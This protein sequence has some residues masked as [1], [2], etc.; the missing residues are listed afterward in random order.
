MDSLPH[1]LLPACRRRN[2]VQAAYVDAALSA[3]TLVGLT[4]AEGFALKAGV[5]AQVLLRVLVAGGPCKAR[6]RPRECMP[7]YGSVPDAS[8]GS[9]IYVRSH[10][11]AAASIVRVNRRVDRRTA[12]LLDAAVNAA[13]SHGVAGAAAE[14]IDLGVPVELVFR[15]LCR[16]GARRG[17][18]LPLPA[19]NALRPARTFPCRRRNRL[20][21]AYVDAAL[22]ISKLTGGRRAED[23]LVAQGVAQSVIVRILHL[24]GFRRWRPG[25]SAALV[26][27]QAGESM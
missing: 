5:P 22:T 21:A 12:L 24:N 8:A 11:A 19:D 13:A 18:V 17:D 1:Q 3:R 4:R 9:S 15:V 23:I 14:L 20:Q 7:G 10:D 16:P 26:G 2:H 27:I 6:T 25:A